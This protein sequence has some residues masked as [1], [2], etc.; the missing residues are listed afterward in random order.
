MLMTSGILHGS[1]SLTDDQ[2]HLWPAPKPHNPQYLDV[3]TYG[4]G[5]GTEQPCF[6]GGR[7]YP[8]GLSPSLRTVP[9]RSDSRQARQNEREEHPF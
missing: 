5:Q 2:S 7:T 9:V 6:P 1:Q 8:L 3:F 4:T